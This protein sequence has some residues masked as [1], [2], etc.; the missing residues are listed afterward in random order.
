[1]VTTG[2]LAEADGKPRVGLAFQGGGFAAG[3]LGAGVVKGLVDKKAFDKF[4]I[5]A[6]SGTSAGALIAAAC[7]CQELRYLAGKTGK[8]KFPDDLPK[9]LEDQWMHYALGII[10][11]TTQ[12]QLIRL[13]D[14]ILRLNPAYEMWTE[15]FVVPSLQALMKHWISEFI[16]I[17]DLDELKKVLDV[18]NVPMP[19]LVLGA[20]DVL[21]GDIK[22]FTEKDLITESQEQRLD[23]VRASGSLDEVNGFTII[24]NGPHKGT[25]CDGAWGSNP[26]I[27]PMIDCCVDEIWIIENFPKVRAEIPKSHEQKK[28][29]QDELWQNSLVEKE[30]QQIKF[31]NANLDALNATRAANDLYRRITIRRLPMLLDL[32]PGAC[33]V[34]SPSFIHEMIG[35]GYTEACSFMDN[36]AAEAR[37]EPAYLASA[38]MLGATQEQSNVKSTS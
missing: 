14:T 21:K 34:N 1:M 6:F 8:R 31:V 24:E 7:W 33:F 9:L 30:I 10:Q 36:L 38:K 27:E 5:I 32:G 4:D 12:A 15:H 28:D 22:W 23:L 25:Y 18:K 3:A 26:P 20:A 16:E 19:H 29:R 13:A 11:N 2:Q 37:V 17:T 35:Y